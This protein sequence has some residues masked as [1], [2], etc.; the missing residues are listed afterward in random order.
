MQRAP[1]R[2]TGVRDRFLASDPGLMRLLSALSTVGAVLLTL[3]TL[4]TL[5]APVPTLVAAALTALVST[6][7][8]TEPRPHDQAVTLAAG[9]PVALATVTVGS[10]LAP[11]RIA[12]HVV[13]VALIFAAG[14]GTGRSSRAGWC[15]STPP[16][17]VRSWSGGTAGCS[18][19]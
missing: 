18:A 1:R 17:P 6:A 7:A 14:A 11:Y 19:R 10:A 12:A 5:H 8:V 3:G 9:V 13:F 16:P 4:R 15:S 2:P